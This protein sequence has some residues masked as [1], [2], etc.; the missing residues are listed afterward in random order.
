MDK[1]VAIETAIAAVLFEAHK[2]GF[3]ID[4]ICDAAKSGL[5]DGSK[6][7]RWANA[8]VVVPAQNAIDSALKIAKG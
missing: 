3:D 4:R 6:P 2:L 5:V 8:H 1:V 7:Y